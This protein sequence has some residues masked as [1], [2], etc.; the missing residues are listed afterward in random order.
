MP[1]VATFTPALEADLRREMRPAVRAFR[2]ALTAELLTTMATAATQ[3]KADVIAEIRRAAGLDAPTP[4]RAEFAEDPGTPTARAEVVA[5]GSR[6]IVS[7]VLQRKHQIRALTWASVTSEELLN[8]IV[9]TVRDGL[10]RGG[11]GIQESLASMFRG[12]VA[13]GTVDVATGEKLLNPHKL[14]A[15]H[16]TQAMKAYNE[17]RHEI[18]FGEDVEIVEAV[19]YSA[20]MDRRTS[21]FCRKWNG[22]VI[23]NT[24][25]NRALID[26]LEPP[27]HVRCRSLLVPIT[28]FED[29]TETEGAVNEQPQQGFGVLPGVTAE[30]A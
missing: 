2:E 26:E 27:N 12:W 20:I 25:D 30:A 18:M 17:G 23:A 4:E 29:W 28:K 11:S 13:D 3:G 7:D 5:L 16:R 1:E 19:Q 22:R 6:R 10:D 15:I 9:G 24:P 14:E 8:R 21:P